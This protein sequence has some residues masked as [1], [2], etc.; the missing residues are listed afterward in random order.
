MAQAQAQ[1]IME[2]NQRLDQQIIDQQ[3]EIEVSQQVLNQSLL[4]SNKNAKAYRG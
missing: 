2:E 1:W 4:I 3:Y